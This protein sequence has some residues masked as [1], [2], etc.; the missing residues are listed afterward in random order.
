MNMDWNETEGGGEVIFSDV[1][2][3]VGIFSSKEE[4]SLR[5]N[6]FFHLP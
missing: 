3:A 1:C 6:D 4:V 2:G 5:G